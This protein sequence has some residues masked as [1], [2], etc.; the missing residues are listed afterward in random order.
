[1]KQ[2]Y[3]NKKVIKLIGRLMKNDDDE[4]IVVV[5]NKDDTE[6]YLLNDILDEMTESVISLT[7]D[8]Y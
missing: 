7:S 3:E 5:E 6:E 8:I 4:Y 1:M 2:I